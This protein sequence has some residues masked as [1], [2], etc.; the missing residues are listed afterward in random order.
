[1]FRNVMIGVD[2]RQS[3]RDAIA[4]A[5]ALADPAA[6][7]SLAHIY[8]GGSPGGVGRRLVH[9]SD[10]GW[11]EGSLRLLEAERQTAGIDAELIAVAARSVGHGLHRL[12]DD[13]PAD[14]LVVGSSR[15]AR[16]GHVLIDD[17]ALASLNGAP[18]AVG[19][20][21]QRAAGGCAAVG[22]VGIG[23]D[24]TDEGHVALLVARAIADRHGASLRA[25]H[26]LAPP[27]AG[28]VSPTP[29][30]RGDVLE[31]ERRRAA[32][33]VRALEDVDAAAI[34]GAPFE[35]LA[36]FA[37]RVDLLV[38]GSGSYGPPG[39][40]VLGSIARHLT[41][42]ATCSLLLVP[43]A[44]TAVDASQRREPGPPA[45]ADGS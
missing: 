14:L 20:A 3:G 45:E 1:M 40:L 12:A 11:R 2:G 5:R 22:K 38:V 32:E 21:P 13:T 15:Q 30:R 39:R 35:E 28:F 6:R 43:R 33:H 7:L 37:D 26:V 17:D 23:Y 10:H 24:F 8:V 31:E 4:L 25:L 9:T 18:S 19:I 44:G 27:V 41:R 29:G 36:A 16:A 34:H 42:G